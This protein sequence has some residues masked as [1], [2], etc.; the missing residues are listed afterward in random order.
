MLQFLF[1]ISPQIFYDSEVRELERKL[2]KKKKEGGKGRG[3][4]QMTWSIHTHREK[5]GVVR[6]INNLAQ[7]QYKRSAKYSNRTG[8]YSKELESIRRACKKYFWRF[9]IEFL[10]FFKLSIHIGFSLR[11]EALLITFH[12]PDS[13]FS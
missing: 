1:V 7:Y 2:G 5:L 4:F 13:F 10:N 3:S 12:F 6:E 9:W 11:L 8:K